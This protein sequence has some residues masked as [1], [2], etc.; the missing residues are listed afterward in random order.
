MVPK[1]EIWFAVV[2][3]D[4]LIIMAWI[5]DWLSYKKIHPTLLFGGL[6]IIA[7]QIFELLMFDNSV[8]RKLARLVYSLMI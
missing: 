8:W 4:S 6:L 7:E 1:P 3:A 2:L 5:A